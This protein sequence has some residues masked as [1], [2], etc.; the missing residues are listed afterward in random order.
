MLR[1]TADQQAR[2]FDPYPASTSSSLVHC[3]HNS[4]NTCKG[5]D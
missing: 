2:I 1:I 5:P 4:T 3:G